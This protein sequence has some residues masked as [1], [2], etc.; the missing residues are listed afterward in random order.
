MEEYSDIL[1]P[2]ARGMQGISESKLRGNKYYEN[3]LRALEL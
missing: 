3:H 2:A 1:G